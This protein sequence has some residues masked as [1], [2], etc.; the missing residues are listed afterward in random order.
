MARRTG[1]V[2]LSIVSTFDERGAKKA[3]RALKDFQRKFE[4]AEGSQAHKLAQSSIALDQQA[5]KW[6]NLGSRVQDAGRTMSGVGN[7]LTAGLTVPIVA[8]GIAMTNTAMQFESAF[9]GVEK[10]VDGTAEQMAALEQGIRDMALELPATREEIAGVAE[11]AGQLGIQTDNILEFT[12]VMVDLGESTN[13]SATDGATAL[14]RFANITQMSQDK[15]SNLGSSIVA[16]GNNMATTESEITEFA[17]RL[18][19]AGAQVGM[20]EPD[21]LAIGA[22]LS[23]VGIEAEAGGSAISKTMISIETAVQSGS[24]EL[25]S[26]AKAAGMSADAFTDAW[27]KD[28]AA[29]LATVVKGLGNMEAQ[30]GSTLQML[31]ELGI[32]ETRQR[33]AL[34]RAAGAGDLLTNALNTSGKAWEENSALSE[35]AAK[36]YET[37]ASQMVILQNKVSDV[38]LEFG[39]ALIPALTDA[40]DA[41]QPVIDW[42]KELAEKFAALD[43]EEQQQV[44]KFVALAAAIGP[45]LA[46]TGNLVTVVGGGIKAYGAINAALAAYTAKQAAAAAAT[47]ASNTALAATAGLS[48]GA[49]AGLVA[50]AGAVGYATGSLINS[51]PAVEQTT[52]ALAEAAAESQNLWEYLKANAER[53]KTWADYLLPGITEVQ[54][55]AGA[56]ATL[57][58]E[59][60]AEQVATD[61]TVAKWREMGIELDENNNITERGLKQLEAR[62]AAMR[63]STDVTDDNT[64]S[65]G[66]LTDATNDAG[67]ADE[68]AAW[69]KDDYVRAM[70]GQK[71]AADSLAGIERTMAELANDAA[72]ADLAARDATDAY[73]EALKSGDPRKAEEARLRMEDATWRAHDATAELNEQAEELNINLDEIP[74]P[75]TSDQAAWEAYYKAIAE[76]AAAAASAAERANSALSRR[77]SVYV[78]PSNPNIPVYGSGGKVTRPHLAIVGDEEEYIINPK[79][80][81]AMHLLGGLLRDMGMAGGATTSSVT[82]T[83][84]NSRSITIAPGAVQISAS[85]SS[86][87]PSAIAAEVDAALRRI[88]R[89]SQLMGA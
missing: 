35:E 83:V 3:E 75:S 85:G 52:D 88:V 54:V 41:A 44:L 73:N 78:D 60:K 33:D 14:A 63:D 76:K 51:I 79:A 26:W 12:R 18:A 67:A 23:S 61:E 10:T 62:N 5:A 2:K 25:D 45:V 57:T 24:K 39:E 81:N 30:G 53:E 56:M 20:T 87:S 13:M 11:A 49:Q 28:P 6:K 65:L 77:G 15:F 69:A 59:H 38:A 17:L 19:G 1:T 31:E 22:A 21:I 37:F 86:A 36:R 71:V 70:D 34:L 66:I 4:V 48:M 43:K 68:Y 40:I 32:T 27:E 47:T 80:P 74:K 50:M 29:A 8:A 9:A 84:S 72:Q 46:V 42:A 89:S 7:A 16:L 82:S 55:L 58:N 64:R